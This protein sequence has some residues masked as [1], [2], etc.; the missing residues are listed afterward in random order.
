MNV[1]GNRAPIAL[2]SMMRKV[3]SM[4]AASGDGATAASSMPTGVQAAAAKMHTS[5]SGPRCGRISMP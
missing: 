2:I 3:A 1:I 4:L 5:V